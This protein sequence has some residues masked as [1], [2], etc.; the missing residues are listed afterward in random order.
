MV[1]FEDMITL[2]AERAHL[3]DRVA[4]LNELA[5]LVVATPRADAYEAS[6]VLADLLSQ[7]GVILESRR[8]DPIDA[9]RHDDTPEKRA[10]MGEWNRAWATRWAWRWVYRADRVDSS[11]TLSW[12]KLRENPDNTGDRQGQFMKMTLD[13]LDGIF[14]KSK[15][16]PTGGGADR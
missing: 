6:L 11:G 14:P 5:Q 2:P 9:P 12:L 3:L 15:A 7:E 16:P 1:R 8:S 13:R 10:R 4:Q